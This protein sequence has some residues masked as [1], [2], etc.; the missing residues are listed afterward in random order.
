MDRF[1]FMADVLEESKKHTGEAEQPPGS[2]YGPY[3]CR[4][5][6][7][8]T[9]R[10]C[11]APWCAGHVTLSVQTV[12]LRNGGPEFPCHSAAVETWDKQLAAMGFLWKGAL[13]LL[14]PGA[15]VCQGG[16]HITFFDGWASGSVGRT[17]YG[18]GGN[19]GN[20]VQRSAYTV[21]SDTRFYVIPDAWD[22]RKPVA[23]LRPILEVLVNEDGQTKRVFH[24]RH[25]GTLANRVRKAVKAGATKIVIRKAKD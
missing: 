18:H 10:S 25:V 15:I 8:T 1:T 16:R 17:Y 3:V 6:A 9:Y 7:A 2:N 22:K 4:C 20:R 5:L 19:Q 11:R 24:G 21:T 12:A 13:G 14:P 23:E